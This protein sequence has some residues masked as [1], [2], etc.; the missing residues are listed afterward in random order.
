[1]GKEE[2]NYSDVISRLPEI[3]EEYIG[4]LS[5]YEENLELTGKPHG[6][7]NRE[8]PSWSAYYDER[9]VELAT[10]VKQ[11]ESHVEYVESKLWKSYTQNMSLSL[12]STDKKV[13]VK[14]ESAYVTA[15]R[16]YL[17]VKELYE[18][19]DAVVEAFK[20]R[21]YSLKNLTELK[22]HALEDALI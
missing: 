11:V 1:M 8:Q 21:G 17:E 4:Y 13:Y 19:Y 20:T 15:N 14:S 18:K 12:S 22:V 9:R 10:I 3:L 5:G 7:A 16:M 2:A 6:L